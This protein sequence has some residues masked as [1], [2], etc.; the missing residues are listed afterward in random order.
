[1]LWGKH[2]LRLFP[3]WDY[4]KADQPPYFCQIKRLQK[5]EPRQTVHSTQF[6][7]LKLSI[8]CILRYIHHHRTHSV[9]GPGHQDTEIGKHSYFTFSC[10][11]KWYPGRYGKEHM[12]H[13]CSLCTLLK[14][15]CL[16]HL[17]AS[18]TGFQGKLMFYMQQ[19]DFWKL[20]AQLWCWVTSGSIKLHENEQNQIVK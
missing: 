13:R 17:R 7:T 5:N 18:P 9:Q 4:S 2:I 6:S 20:T 1:M 19:S 14:D 16:Q 11:V 10:L 3:H 12:A 8:D 15:F